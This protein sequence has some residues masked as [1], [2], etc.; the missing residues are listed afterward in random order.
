MDDATRDDF[1]ART[2][3]TFALV[4]H[5]PAEEFRRLK[6]TGQRSSRDDCVV[7]LLNQVVPP[8]EGYRWLSNR[9]HV[10]LQ[11][12][13]DLESVLI[14]FTPEPIREFGERFDRGD[15]PELLDQG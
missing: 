11:I 7:R 1:H 14:V 15:F 12:V 10:R 8:P 13:A 4:E 3:E 5:D 9:D 2:M 6:I